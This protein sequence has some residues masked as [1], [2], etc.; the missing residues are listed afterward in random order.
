[1]VSGN[2][3]SK[4]SFVAVNRSDKEDIALKSGRGSFSV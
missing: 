2:R 1:L 3:V 4:D